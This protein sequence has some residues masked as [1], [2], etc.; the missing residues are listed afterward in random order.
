MNYWIGYAWLWSPCGLNPTMFKCMKMCS[1]NGCMSRLRILESRLGLEGG[2]KKETCQL[3][4]QWN[5]PLLCCP[6]QHVNLLWSNVFPFDSFKEFRSRSLQSKFFTATIVMIVTTIRGGK[7]S[8]EKQL[9][10]VDGEGQFDQDVL[11]F[12]NQ[13][14]IE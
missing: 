2:L 5:P 13:F 14:K 11:P 10:I 7:K 4:L 9:M 12:G 1:K 3:F 8:H 6:L